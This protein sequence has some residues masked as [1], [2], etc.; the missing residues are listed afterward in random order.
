MVMTLT[1]DMAMDDA[2]IV[3]MQDW[4]DLISSA[5]ETEPDLPARNLVGFLQCDFTRMSCGSL[6]LDTAV[7]RSLSPTL[8]KMGPVGEDTLGAY[9][10]YWRSIKVLE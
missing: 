6:V 9:V 8:R 1:S 3:P 5:P 2:S 7:A 4:F 10:E